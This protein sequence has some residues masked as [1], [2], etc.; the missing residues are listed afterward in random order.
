MESK[1]RPYEVSDVDGFLEWAC[2]DEVIRT[3]RLRHYTQREDALLIILRKLHFLIHG[4]GLYVW[5]TIQLDSYVSNQ[6]RYYALGS[7]YWGEGITTMAV[8]MVISLV[9]LNLKSFRT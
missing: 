8:K 3:S 9:C 1:L 4:T 2:D 6:V 5:R 7:Q